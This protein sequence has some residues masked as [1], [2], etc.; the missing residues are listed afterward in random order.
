[1]SRIFGC[2]NMSDKINLEDLEHGSSTLTQEE[3]DRIK[4]DYDNCEEDDNG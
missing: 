1:M 3:R 2:V 4:A